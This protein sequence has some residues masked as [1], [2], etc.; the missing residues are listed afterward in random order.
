MPLHF[1]TKIIS[2]V[3][4][5][6]WMGEGEIGKYLSWKILVFS[7]NKNLF[8]VVDC[9]DFPWNSLVERNSEQKLIS[10]IARVLAFISGIHL[11]AW[12]DG[13]KASKQLW[14]IWLAGVCN[15]SVYLTHC[16]QDEQLLL[17]ILCVTIRLHLIICI[18]PCLLEKN[19]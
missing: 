11:Q 8:P 14:V 17:M 18:S 12:L 19:E 2:A 4:T 10:N 3:F 15:Y 16:V 6:S 1:K 13:F 5:I 9:S 7:F